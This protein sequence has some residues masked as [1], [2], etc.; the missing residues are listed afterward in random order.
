MSNLLHSFCATQQTIL[1][2]FTQEGN[3]WTVMCEHIQFFCQILFKWLF[4]F[5]LHTMVLL[6]IVSPTLVIATH[7]HFRRY[8]WDEMKFP[9]IFNCIL[10]IVCKI[11]LHFTLFCCCSLAIQMSYIVNYLLTSTHFSVRCYFYILNTDWYF[12][13]L[14]IANIFS[15]F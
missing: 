13:V 7:F 2:L 8:V 15:Q 12:E 14:Y 5:I 1:R 10:L 6:P 3:Y 11:G 4:Q 9:V